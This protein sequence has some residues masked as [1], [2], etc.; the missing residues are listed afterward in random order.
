MRQK[1][2]KEREIVFS[3]WTR[4]LP[5]ER[6]PL[7]FY[8]S[9]KLKSF[10]KLAY[11]RAFIAILVRIRFVYTPVIWLCKYFQRK[12]LKFNGAPFHDAKV[13]FSSINAPRICESYAEK[14]TW[15]VFKWKL[16][17][18]WKKIA[19]KFHCIIKINE[20]TMKWFDMMLMK[21][22]RYHVIFEV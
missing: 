10:F 14:H 2:A 17:A 5:D 13:L 9:L 16:K 19:D 7:H 20:F 1:W 11:T 3:F 12:Y 22:I 6:Q 8:L 15:Y 18:T 21:W 4:I